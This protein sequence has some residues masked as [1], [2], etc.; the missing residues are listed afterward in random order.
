MV[1]IVNMSE[2]I[3]ILK[4]IKQ[5]ETKSHLRNVTRYIRKLIVAIIRVE[6]FDC[7]SIR[8]L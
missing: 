7:K 5:N 4:K 2:N 1:N 6:I 8:F 3:F